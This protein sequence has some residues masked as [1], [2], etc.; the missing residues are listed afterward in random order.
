MAYPEKLGQ[1][2]WDLDQVGKTIA[3]A[4]EARAQSAPHFLAAHSPFK[5][6]SELKP[7]NRSLAEEAVFKELFGTTGR[8][9]QAFVKGEPGTGKS[10][11]IRW[12]QR[13][14]KHAADNREFGL[15]KYQIVLVTRGNGTLKDALQ[16]IVDQ[17]G[18]GFGHHMEKIRNAIDKISDNTARAMLLSELSLELGSRWMADRKRPTLPPS[19]RHLA[20]ALS[21]QSGYGI[22]L[23]REGGLVDQIIRRLTEKSSVDDREKALRFTVDDLVKVPD[24]CLRRENNSQSAIDLIHDLHLDDDMSKAAVEN[25]N[26][27]LEDAKRMLT[28]LN[29]ASLMDTFRQIRQ[30]LKDQGKH[31]AIFIEDVSVTGLD[32]D[33]VNA[34]EPHK[35]DNLCRMISILGITNR[36]YEQLP[37]SQQRRPT[38]IFEVGGQV[39][40]EWASD[41]DEV[42]LFAARYLN[43]V[44]LSEREIS[45]LAEERFEKDIVRSHCAGCSLRD[46]CHDAFG[47]V[48]LE[49]GAKIG[50]F[51]FSRR[52][53]QALLEKLRDAGYKSQRGLLERVLL[54]ALEQSQVAFERQEFPGPDT[55][56]VH[57]P[58]PVD[59]SSFES[60]YCREGWS[61]SSKSRL[62]V[63]AQYWADPADASGRAAE[64][65]KILKPFGLPSFSTAAPGIAAPSSAPPKDKKSTA[66]QPKEAQDI[67]LQ[68]LLSHLEAWSKDKPLEQDKV[69]RD[70][71][72]AFLKKSVSWPDQMEVPFS[73]WDRHID[74]IKYPQI[75]GQIDRPIGQHFFIVFPRDRD[76][77]MLLE[78]LLNFSRAGKNS[79]TFPSAEF[80][81]RNMSQ[82]LRKNRSKIVAA[83][84]PKPPSLAE[85]SVRCAVQAL[86]LASTA[87]DH[88]I[89]RDLDIPDQ[90]GQLFADWNEKPTAASSYLQ[91]L[92]DLQRKH[93]GLRDFLLQEIGVGQGTAAPDKFI[94]P[95]PA[96]AI[97]EAFHKKLQVQPPPAAVSSSYWQSR[98]S[99]VQQLGEYAKLSDW[100]TKERDEIQEA[101][102]K[103]RLFV[104]DC[105]VQG[106]D[107]A[108]DLK[109][110][111]EKLCVVVDLQRK[112]LPLPISSFDQQVY[113]AN[114]LRSQGKVWAAAVTG[115]AQLADDQD[116]FKVAAYDARALLDA[117]N[118]LQLARAHLERINK[119]LLEEEED[120]EADLEPILA[121]LN[122]IAGNSPPHPQAGKAK[123]KTPNQPQSS[124]AS[125]G[126][127]NL[128]ALRQRLEKYPYIREEWQIREQV[129]AFLQKAAPAA[130]SAESTRTILKH[131]GSV[132]PSSEWEGGGADLAEASGHAKSICQ[133]LAES[134]K[135]ILEA[136]VISSF[137]LMIER[138]AS[139]AK[140]TKETWERQVNAAVAPWIQLSAIAKKIMPQEAG[141]LADAVAKLQ[142]K[143]FN[144]PKAEPEAKEVKKNISTMEKAVE[145]LN[146][147]GEFGKFLVSTANDGVEAGDLLKPEVQ[148]ML[149]KHKIWKFFR[150]KIT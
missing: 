18:A 122:K 133:H 135:R 43:T 112:N 131:S 83:L 48:E 116:D 8:E 99:A 25:I 62:K 20:N 137:T 58:P 69:F 102:N 138:V 59:W 64:L 130:S 101:E 93:Q 10:H 38:H 113:N 143:K 149:N 80:H 45:N 37:D 111:L 128:D 44:R 96:L 41:P 142:Q 123:A 98:L 29:G 55:F 9:I 1:P 30:K 13:R 19:L 114:K 16:Q 88:R 91:P 22:W 67:E 126:P 33:V 108:V 53:P 34:F 40:S 27:A 82:W 12:L 95:L 61:E 139:A 15:D 94:N 21:P 81:K 65:T 109:T 106:K 7:S 47:S 107:F 120:A 97:L 85:D 31:F 132:F 79:W 46:S 150:V 39:A 136:K 54:P 14:A 52:A 57:S 119:S 73:E 134:K 66:P 76:T 6:I 70:L 2:C 11:L 51:P 118:C 28:G 4:V 17:L 24:K 77:K 127:L 92:Q 145:S 63:L 105:G 147:K 72:N 75:V 26:I 5:K 90:I 49:T 110:C 3:I 144:P 50:M 60:K 129:D 84:K 56:G 87:R 78:A 115:A 117:E 104:T 32:Q 146:L 103:I 140:I 89:P 42:A 125:S 148:D 100:L 124:T 71:L 121:E 68:T 74:G 141:D 86:A 35:E 23:A 36:G